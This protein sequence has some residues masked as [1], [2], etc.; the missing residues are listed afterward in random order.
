MLRLSTINIFTCVKLNIV[1]AFF[2]LRDNVI[3]DN[4][5]NDDKNF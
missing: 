5:V 4:D 1:G 3:D 2:H